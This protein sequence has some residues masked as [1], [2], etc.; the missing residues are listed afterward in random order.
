MPG[1]HR[2]ASCQLCC[3]SIRH[4]PVQLTQ[5]GGDDSRNAGLPKHARE[6][7][8]VLPSSEGANQLVGYP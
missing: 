3:G 6:F 2:Q 4:A 5:A 7:S 8:K 1:G